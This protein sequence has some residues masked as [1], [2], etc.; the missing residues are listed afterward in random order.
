MPLAKDLRIEVHTLAWTTVLPSIVQAHTDTCKHL[1]IK[2]NY[3]IQNIPHGRWMNTILIKTT[4]DVV[5]FLDIDCVPTTKDIVNKATQYAFHNNS[6]MGIAQ[7]SNHIAPY[8]HIYAAPAFFAISKKGW[9]LMGGPTFEEAPQ[10]DV[11]ENVSYAAEI[12][13]IKYKTLYPTHYFKEPEGGAWHLHTYGEYGIGTYFEGGVFH[14]YQGRLTD[15][16]HLFVNACQTIVDG[17]FSLKSFRP[18]RYEI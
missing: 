9:D 5:V 2:V 8:S 1:G 12:M 4:A 14:L 6:F 10:C 16:S 17:T 7:V 3:T 15:N 18:S 13:K 11:A